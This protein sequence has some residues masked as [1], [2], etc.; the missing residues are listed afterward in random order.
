MRIAQNGNV[1]DVS[2]IEELDAATA[3]D[4]ESRLSAALLPIFKRINIDLS[5][6]GFADCRGLGALLA[7]RSQA[8]TQTNAMVR[9]FNPNEAVRRLLMLTGVDLLFE[10]TETEIACSP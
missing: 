6:T 10:S 2:D 1:L 8:R 5:G 4:F 9:V 3:A 7:L